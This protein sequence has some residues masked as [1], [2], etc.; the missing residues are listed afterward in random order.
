MKIRI[1]F[2]KYGALKFIGHLDMMRYFQ[3]ALKRAEIDM[4]YSEGFN[5]HMIMSF[6]APLGV[7]ITS[8]GEYF[9]IEVKS[10]RSTEE[11]LRALNH[12]MV[13]GVEVISYVALPDTAKKSMSIVAAADYEIFFKDGYEPPKTSE[14]FEKIFHDFYIGQESILVVKKTKKSEKEMDLKPLIY[15]FR[16]QKKDDKPSFYLKVSTGSVDNIKPEL[17]LAE[18]FA[19]AGLEYNPAAMQI[20]KL[21]TYTKNEQGD[22]LPLDALGEIIV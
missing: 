14:E 6:A 16:I 8:D 18:M 10:T 4:K 2:R 5:P 9:D 19:F 22:F 15:D 13:E 1:K 3:K 21:E 20:H 11:A 12:T 17:V 7:G